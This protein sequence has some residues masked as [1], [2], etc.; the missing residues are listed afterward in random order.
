[1]HRSD[2]S[3]S[4]RCGD[5]VKPICGEDGYQCGVAGGYAYCAREICV[6]SIQY[7]SQRADCHQDFDENGGVAQD[8]TDV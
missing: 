1:M 6:C 5:V 4:A 2:P 3:N 8:H 7:T